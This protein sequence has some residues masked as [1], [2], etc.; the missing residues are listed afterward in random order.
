[1]KPGRI[2]PGV[3]VGVLIRREDD[4]LMLRRTGAHG[5][6]TWTVPGGWIDRGEHW[7]VTAVRETREETGLHVVAQRLV[8]VTTDLHIEDDVHSITLFVEAQ[9]RTPAAD[10]HIMEPDKCTAMAWVPMAKVRG[11]VL[12]LP[13]QSFVASTSFHDYRW[14][15]DAGR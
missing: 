14:S 13:M 8:H 2:H 11:R 7:D 6:G 15:V 5:A 9:M 3:G 4:L 10:P 12:F 1:M